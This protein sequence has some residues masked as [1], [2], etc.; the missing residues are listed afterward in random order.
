MIIFDRLN[1]ADM[2]G[3]VEIQLKRLEKRLAASARS[4]STWMRRQGLAGRRRL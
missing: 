2:A 4:R 3:I 1:R